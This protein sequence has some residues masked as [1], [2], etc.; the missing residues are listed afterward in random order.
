[1]EKSKTTID[2]GQPMA[3]SSFTPRVSV[4]DRL[5]PSKSAHDS[6]ASKHVSEGSRSRAHGDAKRRLVFAAEKGPDHGRK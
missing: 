2:E 5:G 3:T 4:K 6:T 1:M